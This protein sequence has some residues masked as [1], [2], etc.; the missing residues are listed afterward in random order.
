M[1]AGRPAKRRWRGRGRRGRRGRTRGAR[2]PRRVAARRRSTGRSGSRARPGPDRARRW[3]TRRWRPGS[4]RRPAPRRPRRRAPQ[5]VGAVSHAG[6]GSAIRAR[7]PSRLRHWSG[8]SAAGGASPWVAV[9]WG[10]MS[11]QARRSGLVMGLDAYMI[12]ES[13]AAPH[14]PRPH[15]PTTTNETKPAQRRGPVGGGRRRPRLER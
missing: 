6:G 10:V 14:L 5:P 4:S 1:A 13:R 9:G 15:Y 7:Q 3:P 12:A 11:R 8:A 2:S